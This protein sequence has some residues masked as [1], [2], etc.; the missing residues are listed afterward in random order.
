MNG[1]APFPFQ[2]HLT[3][4]AIAYR[5]RRLIA[6][7]V[8]PRVP[9]GKQEFTYLLHKLADGF[10]L[11]ETRVGRT[12]A[13]NQVQFSATEETAKTVDY[14]LDNPVPQAD[15][16]NAPANYD[17]LG[18]ATEQTMD[19][20]LLDREV[21]AASLVFGAA[22][23]GAANKLTLS[24][25]SQWSDPASDPIKAI[26]DALDAMVM[27]PNIGVFGRKTFS[28]LA[29]HP[30]IVKATHGNSGDAGIASRQAV[31]ELFELEDIQVGEGFL[32]VSKP[33]QAVN[34][35]RVWGKHAAFIYRDSLADA[36]HGTTFGFTAQF[37]DRIAGATPDSK[38]GMRGGQMVRVGESIKEL[39]TANDLGYLFE[40]AV[41]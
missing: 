21:R 14:A 18:K 5:N 37:G 10:T 32:N 13:P 27:R 4:V 36:T 41:A 24:A 35:Q 28:A 6:D 3:A 23:Y 22:N 30:K 11:P 39:I 31:A 33:G 29:M 25:G 1:T 9:V 38:I 26:M 19:L 34:M 16:D 7:V 8:L 20:I 40:N 15:I 12:S 17:P 2:P